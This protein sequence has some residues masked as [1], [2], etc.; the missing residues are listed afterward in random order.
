MKIT[1]FDTF[2]VLLDSSTYT[3]K[4]TESNKIIDHLD[5]T[6][7]LIIQREENAYYLPKEC[8]KAFKVIKNKDEYIRS[9]DK[10]E[11]YKSKSKLLKSIKATLNV[12][13][14]QFHWLCK[15]NKL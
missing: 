15:Q 5:S 13:M 3:A 11:I 10:V 1:S 12:P 14:Q 7:D 2:E 9:L 4:I 6:Y 8:I